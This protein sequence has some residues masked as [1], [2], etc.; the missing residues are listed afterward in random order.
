MSGSDSSTEG[1][2]PRPDLPAAVQAVVDAINAGDTEGFVAA[3]AE[4]GLVDD[5][6]RVLPGRDGVRSW[7]DTDAIGQ[8]ARIEVTE[9]VTEGDITTLTFEW[10]S[11]RFNGTSSAIVTV[12]D[13]LVSSFRIPPHRD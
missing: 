8:G 5:W 1:A 3:F 10:T 4:D 2:A 13:G 11:R 9:A 7:A 12:R 6:G